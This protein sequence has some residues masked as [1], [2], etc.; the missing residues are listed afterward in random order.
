MADQNPVYYLWVDA[1]CIN[2]HDDEEK[3]VQVRRMIA[4]FR[5]ARSVIAWLGLKEECGYAAIDYLRDATD[6]Y[7]HRDDECMRGLR[8]ILSGLQELYRRPWLRRTWVRQEVFVARDL[9]VRCGETAVLW[10]TFVNVPRVVTSIEGR[11]WYCERDLGPAGLEALASEAHLRQGTLVE[12]ALTSTPASQPRK[13]TFSRN[14]DPID[15]STVLRTSGHF[16]ATNP[17][18][19]IYGV[20]GMT[21]TATRSSSDDSLTARKFETL[22]VDY[23]KSVSEVF[24]DVAKYFINRDGSLAV[25]YLTDG[26]R[27]NDIDLPSWTPDWRYAFEA[28]GVTTFIDL[29]TERVQKLEHSVYEHF[30][31]DKQNENDTGL[32]RATGLPLCQITAAGATD[33]TSGNE[34]KY[35]PHACYNFVRLKDISSKKQTNHAVLHVPWSQSRVVRLFGLK[36]IDD[37]AHDRYAVPDTAR[38]G[39]WV[40]ILRGCIHPVVLRPKGTSGFELIGPVDIPITE[41]WESL[42]RALWVRGRTRYDFQRVHT[43]NFLLV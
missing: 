12:I 20:L 11:L 2:Q 39:D 3:S 34:V 22:P 38:E 14:G 26:R 32:L 7:D 5:K 18:D 6:A 4:N 37:I 10:S 23:S 8:K 1:I 36:F 25:L 29:L 33:K 27:G 42:L 40:V 13:R 30:R 43:E 28:R 9:W 19:C 24:Q 17:R 41:S 31:A 15:L 21:D 16:D 35:F